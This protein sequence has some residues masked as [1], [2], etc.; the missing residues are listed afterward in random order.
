MKKVLF[1]GSI[2]SHYQQSIIDALK[3]SGFEVFT[4][5]FEEYREVNRLIKFFYK[6]IHKRK[7]IHRL[8]GYNIDKLNEVNLDLVF[9]VND[10]FMDEDFFIVCEKRGIP[11]YG[12]CMDA[13]SFCNKAMEGN[14]VF[15]HLKYYTAYYSYEPSDVR[16]VVKNGKNVKYLPIG[17]DERYFSNDK[18]IDKC[19]YDIFFAGSLD[20]RRR[21]LL[22]EIA[23]YAEAN[24]LKMIVKT[25]IQLKKFESVLLIP[26]L[27]IRQSKFKAKYPY[28]FRCIDNNTLGIGKI[29]KVYAL[30]R[31]CINIHSGANPEEHTGPNPRTFETMAAGSCLVTDVDHLLGT[32]FVD[33]KELIAY[34]DVEDLIKKLDYYNNN[35]KER[36]KLALVGRN[37]CWEKFT[38]R[39][40]I[41]SLLVEEGLCTKI[42]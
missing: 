35:E 25:G 10:Y 23:K 18:P 14:D 28:L 11:V 31:F 13:L 36:Q 8:N 3:W 41:R 39:K 15:G 4:P 38:Q 16:Y 22:N 7:F 6:N 32:G 12:Y 37:A 26:K 27:L 5:V 29:S 2:S 9:I 19:E 24:K 20:N 34:S 21:E 42:F 17:F 33:G 30:S 40:L 1:I